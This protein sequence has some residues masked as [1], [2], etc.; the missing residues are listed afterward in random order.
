VNALLGRP[1]LPTGVLPLTSVVTVVRS[2][3]H[4]RLSVRFADGRTETHALSRLAGFATETENPG[5]R[6]GVELTTVDVPSP[7]LSDGLQLVDT[8]GVGSVHAHNTDAAHAFVAR[9]DAALVVLSA[10]QPL[11]AQE[12]DLLGTVDRIAGR[13][14]VV[15]NRIDRLDPGERESAVGFVGAALAAAA[16]EIPPVM[17]VSAREGTGIEALRAWIAQ[18][19]RGGGGWAAAERAAR[20]ALARAA[21]EGLTA[22]GVELAALDLPPARLDERAA[23]FARR[24][25]ALAPAREAAAAVLERGVAALLQKRATEPL[26]TLAAEASPRLCD[27]LAE[28]AAG[29]S[30]RSPRDLRAQL[31]AWVDDAVRRLI[32]DTAARVEHE[33][34]SEL[35]ELVGRY[36]AHVDGILG[37]L[38]D[39]VAEAFGERPAWAAPDIGVGERPPLHYKLRDEDEALSAALSAAR[40]AAPGRLGRRM[41]RREQE[42]RL[43]AMVDRHAGRLREQVARQTTAAARDYEARLRRAVDEAA[44]GVGTRIAHARAEAV[45]GAERVAQRRA[46]LLAAAAACAALSEPA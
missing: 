33:V 28:H 9:T 45:L 1:L 25:E 17:A 43:R 31:A 5:N 16:T 14:L 24:L 18:L 46:V 44:E 22:A 26:R 37:E 2:G 23:A 10:D 20:R 13:V 8:P 11:S 35:S 39:G 7:L 32:E 41:V 4:D 30:A 36:A 27:Q 6:L 34:G 19:P 12:R 40:A 29:S 21:A 3:P 38:A 15:L 42:A